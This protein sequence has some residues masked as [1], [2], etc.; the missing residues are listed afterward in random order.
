MLTTRFTLPNQWE[1]WCS[2]SL[3]IWLCIS[4]WA[5]QFEI[6]AA[7]TRTTVISGVLLILAEVITLSTF[8]AWEEG[9][10]ILLGIWLIAAPWVI[11]AASMVTTT[12]FVI[13]GLLVFAL[14]I[15]EITQVRGSRGHP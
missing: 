3:G 11:G 5:L 6:D 4:P 9:L 13:V 10:N 15:Y 1:D 2:W 8:R 12:N 7:A 14:A